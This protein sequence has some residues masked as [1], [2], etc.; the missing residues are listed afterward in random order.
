MA[1]LWAYVGCE[2]HIAGNFGKIPQRGV[3]EHLRLKVDRK[4]AFD[5]GVG[6]VNSAISPPKLQVFVET[7]DSALLSVFRFAHGGVEVVVE[8]IDET[9]SG[10]GTCRFQTFSEPGRGTTCQISDLE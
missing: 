3:I 5:H 7:E 10:C 1:R 2:K 9:L 8:G 6:G 4:N